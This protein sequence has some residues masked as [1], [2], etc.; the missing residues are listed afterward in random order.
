MKRYIPARG[1]IAWIDFP[2]GAGHEQAHRRP[3]LFL[4]PKNYNQVSGLAV[5][6]PISRTLKSYPFEVALSGQLETEGV[7]LSDQIQSVAWFQR[8]ADYKETAADDLLDEVVARV[9]ALIV[10]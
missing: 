9:A 8:N 3:A 4:S 7:V 6:C 5:V 10:P 1:D 2:F